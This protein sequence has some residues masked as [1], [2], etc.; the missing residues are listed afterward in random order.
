M[1]KQL[2]VHSISIKLA[3]KKKVNPADVLFL[4]A[5]VNYTEVFL[6]GGE[7]L[8]VSKTLKELEKRFLIYGFFRTH[9]SYM[10]NL[11]FVIG[12]QI[13]EGLHVKL[14]DQ[15]N[16]SLSRRRKEVFLDTVSRFQEAS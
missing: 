11:K 2:P 6:Q 10:V 7:K 12:Y 8:I 13:H 3:G 16:V 4:K 1:K 15:H 5:D 9:K 14:L